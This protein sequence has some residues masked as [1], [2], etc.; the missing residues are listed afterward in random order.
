LDVEG[1]IEP[2]DD[3]VSVLNAQVIATASRRVS[4]TSDKVTCAPQRGRSL[5]DF[6]ADGQGLITALKEQLAAER[7]NV[8]RAPKRSVLLPKPHGGKRKCRPARAQAAEERSRAQAAAG[9]SAEKIQKGKGSKFVFATERKGPLTTDAINRQIKTIATRAGL[10]IP[11]HAHM[12]RHTCG[13]MLAAQRHETRRI[14]AW[15]GHVSIQNTVKYTAP[16][17]DAFKDF[18]RD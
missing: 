1:H 18:W 3:F 4:A 11:I 7:L 15:L 13:F 10:S 14:Q 6:K 5:P 16:S 17:P 2:G 8:R 9:L 12:L